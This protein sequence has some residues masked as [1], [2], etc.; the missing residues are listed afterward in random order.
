[1]VV[2]CVGGGVEAAAR[3]LRAVHDEQVGGMDPGEQREDV[4]IRCGWLY[5]LHQGET[6]AAEVENGEA[7]LDWL[8]D[9]LPIKCEQPFL[10]PWLGFPATPP[11]A[12]G[13]DLAVE[14][15]P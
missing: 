15:P 12:L 7:N 6:H 8:T 14:V 13:P 3:S 9:Q 2:E 10:P 11:S 4:G 1:M 5:D